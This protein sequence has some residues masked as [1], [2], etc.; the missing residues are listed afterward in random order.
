MKP[1]TLMKTTL[2]LAAMMGLTACLGGGVGNNRAAAPAAQPA[3][4]HDAFV[5]SL[6]GAYIW[7]CTMTNDAGQAWRFVLAHGDGGRWTP[8]VLREAGA[9]FD[10]DLEVGRLG[11]AR[12]Y[13]LRD[14]SE[15][16]VAADG[17]A[18]G[19]GGLASRPNDFPDGQCSRGT[20]AD[21]FGVTF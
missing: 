1:K 2:A 21:K 16:L 18:R 4:S 10:Q 9:R 17:E 3:V 7:N 12:I 11:A 5:A 6:N 8:V 15:V 14:K 19:S 20:Q 13:R